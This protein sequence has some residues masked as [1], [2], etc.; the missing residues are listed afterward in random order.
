MGY[1]RKEGEEGQEE[2]WTRT[3]KRKK[4]QGKLREG[5]IQGNVGKWYSR[6]ENYEKDK[7]R[8]NPQKRA[9]EQLLKS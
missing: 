2:Y 7:K 9:S 8:G 5:W 6:G 1:T 4:G 3:D